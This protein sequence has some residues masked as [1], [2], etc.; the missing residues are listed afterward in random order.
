MIK[1][2]EAEIV[3]CRH[4]GLFARLVR[5]ITRSRWDHITI[6]TYDADGPL[7]LDFNYP[8]GGRQLREK[9]RPWVMEKPVCNL[10]LIKEHV[11]A[12]KKYTLLFNLNYLTY[13]LFRRA[14]FKGCN[15]VSF[16]ADFCSVLGPIWYSSPEKLAAYL[17]DM[18]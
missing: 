16:V 15:C 10:H 7:Y 1:N 6:K 2:F 14:P 9:E 13:K 17:R 5:L 11:V 4:R 12:P 18:K 3:L 8:H